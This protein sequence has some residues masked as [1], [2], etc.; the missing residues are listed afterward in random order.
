MGHWLVFAVLFRLELERGVFNADRKMLR[1]TGL[2]V[3]EESGEV[4]IDKTFVRDDNVGSEYGQSRCDLR[5]V[6]V[7][8]IAY[9]RQLEDVVAHLVEVEFSRGGFHQH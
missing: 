7:V 1:N 4:T 3:V 5:G 8:H 2:E 6:E 9:V